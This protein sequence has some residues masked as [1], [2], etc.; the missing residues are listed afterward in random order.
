MKVR[1][2]ERERETIRNEFSA[3]ISSLDFLVGATIGR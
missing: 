3:K 1:T 2:R